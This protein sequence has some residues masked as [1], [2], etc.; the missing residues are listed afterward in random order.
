MHDVDTDDIV[1]QHCWVP[2]HRI[3]DFD[4]WEDWIYRGY[5]VTASLR[6]RLPDGSIRDSVAVPVPIVG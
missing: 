3:A 1:A 6:E 2:K 5:Y 4:T